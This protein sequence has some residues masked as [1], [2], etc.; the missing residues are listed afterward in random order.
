MGRTGKDVHFSFDPGQLTPDEI[1]RLAAS[2]W[3]DLA[4]DEAALM[5][6]KRDGLA[7]DGVRLTGPSPYEIEAGG[8]GQIVVTVRPLADPAH[9]EILLDLWQLHFVKGLRPGSL[10]A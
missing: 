4:F 2:M 5:R 10:A 3:S 1:Q 9:A 6:L 7:L 8:D